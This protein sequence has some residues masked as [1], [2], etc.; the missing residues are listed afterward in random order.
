MFE[1][2]SQ[3]PGPFTNAATFLCAYND[4]RSKQLIY[5]PGQSKESTAAGFYQIGFVGTLQN[6]F[7]HGSGM[8]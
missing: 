7:S 6:G 8:P 2:G 5:F 1:A 4:V 3:T